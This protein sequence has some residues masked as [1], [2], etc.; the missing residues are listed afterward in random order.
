VNEPKDAALPTEV[1]APVRLALVVTLLAVNE[2]AVPVMFV[3]TS[4][5]GVPRAGVT[6]VGDVLRT[7][8]PDPVLVVTPVPP[9]VT[10]RAVARVKEENEVTASIT[11]VPSHI[12][13]ITLPLGT[14]IPVPAVVFNVTAKPPVVAFLK[15]YS[16]LA[17]GTIT[18]LATVRATEETMLI[19]AYRASFAVEPSP[20]VNVLSA[21]TI[22]IDSYPA[23]ASS[24]RDVKSVFVRFPQLPEFSPVACRIS[25]SDGV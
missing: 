13:T 25:F 20:L 9:E 11:L 23:T 2:V 24:I 3:P 22:E 18:F 8:L 21:S 19:K 16:L 10:G 12:S 14:E 1:T 5:D 7:L 4:A 6:R 17:V 15:K